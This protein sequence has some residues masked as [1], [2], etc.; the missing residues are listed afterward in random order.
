MKT[1]KLYLFLFIGLLFLSSCD[2][3]FE[4][5]NRDPNNPTSVPADLMIPGITTAAMNSMYSTFVGGDMGVAWAQQISKVQYNDE[6]RFYPRN[7][8]IDRFWNNMYEE[9]ISDAN[10]MYTLAE[11]EGNNNLMGVAL[12]LKAYGFSVVTD[13]FG[14]IPFT[15]AL[16]AEE[17]IIKPVYDTQATV[18]TGLLAMLDEAAALLGTGGAI[19]ANSDIIYGGDAVKWEKF[20]NSLKFRFLMRISAKESVGGQLQALYDEGNL[21]TSNDDEAKLVYRS[22]QPFANPIYENIVYGTRNEWKA[23]TTLVD[24]MAGDNRLPVYFGEN[25]DGEIRGKTPGHADV[26]S[27]DFDYANVSPVGD[28]YLRPEAPGFFMSYPELEFFIAEAAINNLITADAETHFGNGVVASFLANGLTEADADIPT[29]GTGAFALENIGKEKY[30]ALYWQGIEVWSEWRRTGIPE[31]DVVN[32]A[33]PSYTE[34]LRYFYN[35]D[36]ASI[37]AVN[38]DAAVSAQ[39]PDLL[40][41]PVW[42]MP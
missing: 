34:A 42:W 10:K 14:M 26:P 17:G 33:N 38:Y 2:E 18:Y 25:E 39:G 41:T 31:L 32:D 15:E 8:S 12:V 1:N 6:E 22:A 16:S 5:M 4:E 13:C 28:F 30:I 9:V 7:A 20:A 11:A 19:S 3:G 21:F 29:L 40:S 24:L 37:N 35:G 23:C 36:E 27:D